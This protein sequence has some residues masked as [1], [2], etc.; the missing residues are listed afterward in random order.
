MIVTPL[1]ESRNY[2]KLPFTRDYYESKDKTISKSQ[3]IGKKSIPTNSFS[4]PST[5]LTSSSS[6]SSKTIL[7][8]SVDA[9][10]GT[11]KENSSVRRHLESI[12]GLQPNNNLFKCFTLEDG[13]IISGTLAKP[14][15]IDCSWLEEGQPLLLKDMFNAYALNSIFPLYELFG[16]HL[17]NLLG[18]IKKA[19]PSSKDKEE[20]ETKIIKEFSYLHSI[21]PERILPQLSLIKEQTNSEILPIASHF[22]PVKNLLDKFIK[23]RTNS[24][25]FVAKNSEKGYRARL[26][27]K[28][29]EKNITVAQ[30]EIDKFNQYL[31]LFRTFLNGSSNYITAPL[32]EFPSLFLTE[33]D[34]NTMKDDL[35]KWIEF[36]KNISDN[37][38]QRKEIRN[39]GDFYQ[40][41]LNQ[42]PFL[43]TSQSINPK[44]KIALYK[45][46]KREFTGLSTLFSVQTRL[47][48]EASKKIKDN[49]LL[50]KPQAE[51]QHLMLLIYSSYFIYVSIDKI[52]EKMQ[53]ETH[54]SP[55]YLITR[56]KVNSALIISSNSFSPSKSP[57]NIPPIVTKIYENSPNLKVFYDR[58]QE[59]LP[60]LLEDLRSKFNNGIMRKSFDNIQQSFD[61]DKSPLDDFTIWTHNISSFK[62]IIGIQKTL[63]IQL[64]EV[65]QKILSELLFEEPLSEKD[66]EAFSEVFFQAMS[67]F[68]PF[69]FFM[70]DMQ[71]FLKEKEAE[72]QRE[73][74]LIPLELANLII[75]DETDFAFVQDQVQEES[76]SIAKQE[77]QE[78]PIEPSD[79]SI[80]LSLEVDSSP[81][82]LTK[83]DKREI[84]ALC[85]R[86]EPR[87]T[88]VMPVKEL[89]IRNAY[90]TRKLLK[91]LKK[92]GYLPKASKRREGCGSHKVLEN[93]QGMITVV[94]QGGKKKEIPRGTLGAIRR[95]VGTTVIVTTSKKKKKSKKSILSI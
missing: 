31:D 73:E 40:E 57:Q 77:V 87:E 21:L 16:F 17:Y 48:K 95:Q 4:T 60:K 93:K 49:G 91:L 15:S 70:N 22:D 7:S 62:P 33:K 37:F 52:I 71:I 8:K 45:I 55:F 24:L 10:L 69:L 44:C 43:I 72:I 30:I 66:R 38:T 86:K 88:P 56:L 76:P 90:K 20:F 14:Q 13:K 78:K 32:Y 74:Q 64:Q 53:K 68:F 26:Q 84:E 39:L 82:R 79:K 27:S 85:V 12:Q 54:V 6:P 25:P 65:R 11:G 67:P 46:F 50:S 92:A 9:L 34:P 29:W 83:K 3:K 58:L 28:L 5:K 89:P 94:P 41:S 80:P 36:Q 47:L 63:Y 42:L 18:A 61:N 23:K 19:L 2:N 1:E 51:Y 59:Y 35:K 81:E 75:F